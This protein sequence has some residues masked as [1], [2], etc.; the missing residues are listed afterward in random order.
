MMFRSIRF[1]LFLVVTA[2]VVACQKNE[3]TTIES[4]WAAPVA[5]GEFAL[6][7]FFSSDVLYSDANGVWNLRF[8]KDLAGFGL[9][10]LLAIPDTTISRKFVVPLT[11]GPFN[12][13]PN[14]NIINQTENTNIAMNGV[15]LREV[16]LASGKL[17][18]T[19]K[20]YVG[21]SLQCLYTIDG[22]TNNG[23]ATVL[24]VDTEPE[25]ASGPNI[26]TGELDLTGMTLDL[27]GQTGL[28]YNKLVSH[29]LIKTSPFATGG[30]PIYG[31]DSVRIDLTFEN[32]IV[33]Y[34]RG[35]F[36]SEEYA[37]D[38]LVVFAEEGQLPSGVFNI[39]QASMNLDV[40][41]KIGM[42]AIISIDNLT[43][44]RTST[45]QSVQLIG[46][47]I[48]DPMYLTRALDINGNVI[49]STHS[50][51]LNQS[52]SN[53]TSFMN[54]LPN[55]F[56]FQGQIQTNPFGNVSDGND[57]YYKDDFTQA[58]LRIDVPLSIAASDLSFTDTLTLQ[59]EPSIVTP[60]AIR[61]QLE[62]EYPIALTVH[63]KDAN[64]LAFAGNLVVA[65]NASSSISIPITRDQWNTIVN[66]D[67]I[68][69][70]VNLNT[71]NFPAYVQLLQGQKLKVKIQADVLLNAEIE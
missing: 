50:I 61:V 22:L 21:A 70:E 69:L 66:D 47:G 60:T 33:E 7:D 37:I 31:Q 25:T 62:N 10:T 40:D 68:L 36:G 48:Y 18:Y 15:G 14:A 9:D 41:H 45:G 5:Y 46:P 28:D 34:A 57:F 27:S 63:L 3:P 59:L 2:C 13:P 19:L 53:L 58:K 8:I 39:E 49:G 26:Q 65:A 38:Q 23:V 51:A 4:K 17:K 30:Q 24:T 6:D 56:Q 12:V 11:G 55:Q 43:A 16:I 20:S 71:P 42:D 52:N 32:P 29:I 1:I 44:S 54:L 67:L 64:N 35:Y